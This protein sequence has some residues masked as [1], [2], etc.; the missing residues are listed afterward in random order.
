MNTLKIPATIIAVALGSLLVPSDAHAQFQVDLVATP[1]SN[2]CTL[3]GSVLTI[4]PVTGNVTI[5]V[6]GQSSCG[7]TGGYPEA[8][9]AISTLGA[10][11]LST[12]QVGGGTTGTGVV[13]V[14]LGT[15]LTAAEPN[16][17]CITAGSVPSVSHITATGWSGVLCGDGVAPTCGTSHSK[18]VTLA[19]SSTTTDGTVTFNA[20]CSYTGAPSST[21]NSV[22]TSI[23]I[24]QSSAV[25]VVHG[26]AP[27]L[28]YCSSVSQLTSPP[29]S[30][31]EAQRQLT[32]NSSGGNPA[33]TGLDFTRYSAIFGSSPD[34]G[35]T[36]AE[37]FGFPGTNRSLTNLGLQRDKYTSL[38]FRVP[39]G[40]TWL[41]KVGAFAMIPNG[42]ATW[43][44]ISRCPGQFSQDAVWAWSAANAASQVCVQQAD[45][46]TLPWKITTSAS[47]GNCRLIP[48]E[49]YYLNIMQSNHPQ[50]GTSTCSSSICTPRIASSL[51]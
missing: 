17:K 28:D 4:D 41:N 50:M 36:V 37:G 23:T 13:T 46:Q 47:E 40:A 51:L 21:P 25:T 32:G 48:G 49:T 2:S 1:A 27:V 5:D 18:A 10:L 12:T 29:H 35:G 3:N 19:N 30:L 43:F 33:G 31:T 20:S 44:A 11:T 9:T 6:V 34:T 42:A 38:Q 8:V 7:S 39:T 14:T 22:S 15:G 26:T 45:Q 24:A 16:V